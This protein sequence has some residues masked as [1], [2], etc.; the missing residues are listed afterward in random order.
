MTADM[1]TAVRIAV[2]GYD[3]SSPRWASVT[4]LSDLEL[5]A[6]IRDEFGIEGGFGRTCFRVNYRGGKSPE[7][8]ITIGETTTVLSG[9]F[10][11]SAVREAMGISRPDEL[12]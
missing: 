8:E 9:N 11:L 1:K 12:F 3:E 4:R 5:T 6:R 2:N 7:L 10:L